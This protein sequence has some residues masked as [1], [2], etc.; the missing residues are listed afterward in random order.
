[1]RGRS[2]IFSRL[3][4]ALAL[5]AFVLAGAAHRPA[6]ARMV[7]ASAEAGADLAAFLAMGGSLDA[8]C[9]DSEIG[10]AAPHP[11]CPACIL[12]KAM[13][14]APPPVTLAERRARPVAEKAFAPLDRAT[15][16]APRAPPG[17]GPPSL[18]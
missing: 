4:A 10:K 2:H 9:L 12:A 14:T 8:L 17:R 13:L 1:M 18:A 7:P 5:L 6:M 11:G 3:A 15:P 16:H